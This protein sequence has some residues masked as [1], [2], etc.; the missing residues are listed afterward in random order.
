LLLRF[1]DFT[2]EP[3]KKY[4]YR[5][6][7]VLAD[8]NYSLQ[9]N[10]LAPAVLDRHRQESVEA[11]KRNGTRQDFRRI[12]GWSDPSPTV[13][14]PLSGGAKLVDVKIPSAEKYNDEPSAKLLVDSFDTDEKGNAIQAAKEQEFR[15]GNVANMVDKVEYLVEGGLAIDTRDNFKFIT[16]MTLLDVDGGKK[17]SKDMTSPA[18]V[19]LMGPAGDLYIHNELDDKPAVE[20]HKALFEKHAEGSEP[21][22]PGRPSRGPA[23][24]KGGRPGGGA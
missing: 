10:V 12:E 11:R 8:P 2:V 23:S 17:L 9:D 20:Y 16:G 3:G 22:A 13:G 15:R 5:V 19:M 14:I 6:T 7:L 4:R 18:R 21:G 1:F 24:G